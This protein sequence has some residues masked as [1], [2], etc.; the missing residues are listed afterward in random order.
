MRIVDHTHVHRSILHNE[1]FPGCTIIRQLH[2]R[3]VV[4]GGF[5]EVER[6]PFARAPMLPTPL[7]RQWSTPLQL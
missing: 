3:A 6:T 2:M 4:Q 1:H 7:S 5:T